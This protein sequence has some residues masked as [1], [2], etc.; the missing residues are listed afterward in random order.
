MNEADARGAIQ[1][2]LHVA[3]TP[4]RVAEAANLF[5]Q[6]L[7]DAYPGL[8]AE[9]V[10]MVVNNFDMTAGMRWQDRL[11][12][13]AI[14]GIIRFAANP[15]DEATKH[16]TVSCAIAEAFAEH[17][18]SFFDLKAELWTPKRKLTE[19]NDEFVFEMKRLCQERRPTPA[20]RGDTII[21]SVVHRVGRASKKSTYDTARIDI[22]EKPQ[23]VPIA[24]GKESAFFDAAKSRA[25][26]A[27]HMEVAWIRS[28]DG[29]LVIDPKRSR[30]TQIDEW[31][32]I[33]GA[34]LMQEF[35]SFPAGMFSDID[36]LI[37]DVEG[38]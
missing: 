38:R 28:I 10:T 18:E 30:V 29:G 1:L 25:L 12:K 4:E 37:D 16:P 17:G 8:P 34:D 36:Y 7:R 5:G 13:R 21:Y 6:I 19:V 15:N 24:K 3:S 11:G 31:K 2:R 22:D 27:I 35:G 14:D 32:P 26:F 23:D 33:S 9:S 20:M